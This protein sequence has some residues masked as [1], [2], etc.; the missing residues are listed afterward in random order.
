MQSAIASSSAPQPLLK[1]LRRI[2]LVL[3]GDQKLADGIL[4]GAMTRTASLPKGQ[5]P[6]NDAGVTKIGFDAYDAA[7]MGRGA[8]AILT[9]LIT[10]DG[11]LSGRVSQ[12][13]YLERIAV[14]LLLI[15]DMTAIDGASL[16]GRPALM[17]EEAL[18]SALPKLDMDELLVS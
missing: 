17:L 4:M 5:R 13:S 15:E 6:V 14:S 3:T 8:I 16:S 10:H 18:A 11:S 2:G 9:R 12:L 7:C 1:Q